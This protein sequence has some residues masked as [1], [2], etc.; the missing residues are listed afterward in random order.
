MSVP[1]VMAKTKK[2]L[3]KGLN[4]PEDGGPESNPQPPKTMIGKRKKRGGSGQHR[5]PLP[6]LDAGKEQQ[7]EGLAHQE[8]TV[9]QPEGVQAQQEDEMEQREEPETERP[10]GEGSRGRGSGLV[11]DYC[12]PQCTL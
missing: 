12:R 11:K 7:E 5:T 6:N 10:E 9:A 2:N 4:T 3:K 8:G 1:E